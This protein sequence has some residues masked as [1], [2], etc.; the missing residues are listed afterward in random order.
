MEWILLS[1]WAFIPTTTSVF[2]GLALIKTQRQVK[3]LKERLAFFEKDQRETVNFRHAYRSLNQ[4]QQGLQ[5]AYRSLNQ[6]RQKL[7]VLIKKLKAE[8][9][10]LLGQVLARG[11]EIQWLKDAMARL[12]SD[13]VGGQDG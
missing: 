2:L 3:G 7:L 8:R 13:E 12:K 9:G 10:V 11:D 5:H 1:L 4:D 6:D